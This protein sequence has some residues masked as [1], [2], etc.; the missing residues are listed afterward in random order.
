[1]LRVS[2]ASCF[3][4]TRDQ[5]IAGTVQNTCQRTRWLHWFSTATWTT[6]R[7]HSLWC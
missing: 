3:R 4:D 7:R 1:M 5:M 6:S 2:E